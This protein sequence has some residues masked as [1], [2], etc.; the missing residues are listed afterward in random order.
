M[1][2]LNKDY[3]SVKIVLLGDDNVGKTSL[4]YKITKNIF[5]EKIDS[6]IGIDFF[7]KD[8]YYHGKKFKLIIWDTSGQKR[9][10]CVLKNYYKFA[11]L[12]IIVFD[13][14]NMESFNSI[15]FWIK[16]IEE[17]SNLSEYNILLIGNKNDLNKV[18]SDDLIK[19]KI[20]IYNLDFIKISLKDSYNLY[21][22]ENKI[23]KKIEN[24]SKYVNENSKLI[25]KDNLK[26]NLHTEKKFECCC[27]II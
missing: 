24:K 23:Y 9:Y 13:L 15:D 14:S 25:E 20:K 18:V 21:N 19:E 7:N 22:L 8:I 12:Y 1:S 4:C 27:T 6:T 17:N 5:R 11:Q 3:N 16:E 10:R 2:Y 26:L